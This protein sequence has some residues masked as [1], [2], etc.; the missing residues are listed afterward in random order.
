MAVY[1][2]MRL[3]R[4][5]FCGDESLLKGDICWCRSDLWWVCDSGRERESY[6]GVVRCLGCRRIVARAFTV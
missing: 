1:C 2:R 5:D 3:F 4:V 6:L